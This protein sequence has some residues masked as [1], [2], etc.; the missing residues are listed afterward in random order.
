MALLTIQRKKQSGKAYDNTLK[1]TI[2]GTKVIE[3]SNGETT[4]INLPDGT[5]T[6]SLSYYFKANLS[7]ALPISLLNEFETN[8][9]HDETIDLQGN[10]KYTISI[11]M[12]QFDIKHNNISKKTEP[13]SNFKS[14]LLSTLAKSWITL[15]IFILSLSILKI[16]IGVFWDH[17][18]FF[19]SLTIYMIILLVIPS[20]VYLLR[21][22]LCSKESKEK[23]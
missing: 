16:G 13:T 5:H 8:C 15:G 14:N 22:L 17:R 12:N 4:Q 1:I 11:G 19:I 3:I 6:I 9:K 21:I 10:S 18:I 23:L 20:F 7:I 2:D